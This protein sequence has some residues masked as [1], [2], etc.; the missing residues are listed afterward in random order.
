MGFAEDLSFLVGKPPNIMN[1]RVDVDGKNILKAL[2][3]CVC[4]IVIL[5]NLYNVVAVAKN[6]FL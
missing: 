6:T 2:S 4:N 1:Y 3:L 5:Y